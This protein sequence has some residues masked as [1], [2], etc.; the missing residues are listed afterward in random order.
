MPELEITPHPDE[1]RSLAELR[2]EF[3]SE[4]L[5]NLRSQYAGKHELGWN[6]IGDPE[7]SRSHFTPEQW[8]YEMDRHLLSPV[9]QD[10]GLNDVPSATSVKLEKQAQAALSH[11]EVTWSDDTEGVVEHDA[12]ACCEVGQMTD[13]QLCEYVDRSIKESEALI[14]DLCKKKKPD[15]KVIHDP[16]VMDDGE[17]MRVCD[18]CDEWRK[19]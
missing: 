18:D 14:C 19:G 9:S 3:R 1:Q 12:P 11:D 7:T 15:V 10:F 16:L 13:E 5:A 8:A 6:I 4:S 2:S 17:T